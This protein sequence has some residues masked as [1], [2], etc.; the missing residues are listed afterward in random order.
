MKWLLAV[1]S[2]AAVNSAFN[3]TDENNSFSITI[4]GHWNCKSAEKVFDKLI[5]LIDLRSP[6][7]NDLHVEQVRNK[8]NSFDKKDY[9]L[10]SLGSFKNEKLEELKNSK[11]NDLEDMV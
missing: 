8:R 4:L 1:C 10:S 2:V 5:K 7:D 11:Y 3:T 6:N 9:S